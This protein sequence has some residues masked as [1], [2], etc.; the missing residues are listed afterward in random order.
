LLSRYLRRY[1]VEPLRFILTAATVVKTLDESFYQDLP[2]NL[3]EGLG[4]LLA[5]NVKAYVAP[6]SHGAFRAAL[7]DMP[8]S[9]E[10]WHHG[11]GLVTLDTL[12]PSPPTVFLLD[13]LRGSGRLVALTK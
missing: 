5:A 4:R 10:H 11:D 3:L 7:S 1:S 8:E 13:Y 12:K 2:G 9:V 6:M